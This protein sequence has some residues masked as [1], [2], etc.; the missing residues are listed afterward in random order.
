[1]NSFS[2]EPGLL[3]KLS[4]AILSF[5]TN[6]VKSKSCLKIRSIC[7]TISVVTFYIL[8]SFRS[9]ISR[10]RNISCKFTTFF[11]VEGVWQVLRKYEVIV[12]SIISW[13]QCLRTVVPSHRKLKKKWFNLHWTQANNCFARLMFNDNI[14]I[15]VETRRFHHLWIQI[16]NITVTR[17]PFELPTQW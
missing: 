12:S 3:I 10:L 6:F 7:G 5:E 8:Q 17:K 2:V 16:V 1:M 13:T 9:K 14:V 11:L 4:T 15:I